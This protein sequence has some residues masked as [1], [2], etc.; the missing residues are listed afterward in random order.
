ML[1]VYHVYKLKQIIL[2]TSKNTKHALWT[3]IVSHNAFMS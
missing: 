1:L 2:V 3:K